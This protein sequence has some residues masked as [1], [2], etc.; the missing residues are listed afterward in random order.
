MKPKAQL[1]AEFNATAAQQE[2]RYVE[3]RGGLGRALQRSMAIK[4][5]LA[6]FE[7]K[8]ETA[9]A[10]LEQELNTIEDNFK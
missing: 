3:V 1:L 7:F 6:S 5:A 8:I 10:E 9:N 4:G 2:A